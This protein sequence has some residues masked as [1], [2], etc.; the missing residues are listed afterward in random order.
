MYRSIPL[1]SKTFLPRRSPE[2]RDFLKRCLDK[3]VDNRWNA[4]QL[5]QVPPSYLLYYSIKSNTRWPDLINVNQE[6][7][8]V[9]HLIP[10]VAPAISAI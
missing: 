10:F 7:I 8:P 4:S 6:I 3:H 1:T 9:T 5:L 2:F